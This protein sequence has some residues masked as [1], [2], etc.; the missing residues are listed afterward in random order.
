MILVRHAKRRC[1]YAGSRNPG[2][3]SDAR[4]A[5]R[6]R[7]RKPRGCRTHT[8]GRV[9]RD[10]PMAGALPSRRMERPEGEAAVG[11]SAETRRPHVEVALQHGYP[12]EPAAT[13]ISVR[14]MDPRDGGGA[15]R[16]EVR[17]PPGQEL[18][19]PAVGAARHYPAKAAVPGSGA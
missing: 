15:D 14:A 4:G 8:A 3:P 11:A 10:V 18:G 13:Q 17:H 7:R 12:K 16:E 5:K 2:G 9:T 19:G 6:A 1:A